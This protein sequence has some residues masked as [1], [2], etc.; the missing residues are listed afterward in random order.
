MAMVLPTFTRSGQRF[1]RGEAPRSG[2]GFTLIEMMIT[3]LVL[4]ILIVSAGPS[5]GRL[6]RDQRIKTVTFDVYA[7]LIYA[8][9]EAVKRNATVD[10]VPVAPP[11]WASGWNIVTGTTTLKRQSAI[12]D[13]SITGPAGAVTYRTSGRLSG[14]VAP[15]FILK[16]SQSDTITARCVRVDLS[17]RPNIKADTDRNPANGCQ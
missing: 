14:N 9:S 10:I 17:G 4:T 15:N 12:G 1:A 5:L 16:S 2:R 13:I 6:M 7:S 3:I 11:D 8:R